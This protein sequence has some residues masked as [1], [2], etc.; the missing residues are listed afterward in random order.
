MTRTSPAVA[1]KRARRVVRERYAAIR[2]DKP[3]DS[4]ADLADKL[5]AILTPAAQSDPA[6]NSPAYREYVTFA[7]SDR[8][9]ELCAKYPVPA[10]RR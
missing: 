3:A 4:P 6:P 1:S 8:F 7:F 9:L 5:V 2:R 10:R